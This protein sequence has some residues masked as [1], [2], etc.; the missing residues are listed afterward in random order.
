MPEPVRAEL[1]HT[2]DVESCTAE[3]RTSKGGIRKNRNQ[4][5]CKLLQLQNLVTLKF[6]PIW[7]VCPK[8]RVGYHN[9]ALN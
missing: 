9:Y 3:R 6:K 1:K 4:E 7:Y 8:I 5:Y 2:A